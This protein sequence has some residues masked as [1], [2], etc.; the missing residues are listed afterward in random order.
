MYDG[1]KTIGEGSLVGSVVVGEEETTPRQKAS[2]VVMSCT[3]VE[4]KKGVATSVEERNA[5]SPSLGTK[6]RFHP[7]PRARDS[8][9][10]PFAIKTFAPP[11]PPP[12]TTTRIGRCSVTVIAA[13]LV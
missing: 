6:F 10:P 2:A 5:E 3:G 12:L 7:P 11:P 4:G 8:R 9:V 13:V 1:G